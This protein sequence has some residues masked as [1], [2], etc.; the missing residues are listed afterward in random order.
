M[1]PAYA[2]LALLACAAG[3]AGINEGAWQPEWQLTQSSKC[4]HLLR[5]LIEVGAAVPAN[6]NRRTTAKAIVYTGV[7]QRLP[8]CLPACPACP[9]CLPVT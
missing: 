8:A 2:A 5:R 9:A 4:V 1:H 6:S 3:A 7:K